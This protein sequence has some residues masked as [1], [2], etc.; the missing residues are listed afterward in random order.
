MWV[1][2]YGSTVVSVELGFCIVLKS[3]AILK[4]V[5]LD[6]AGSSIKLVRKPPS[7]VASTCSRT[8]TLPCGPCAGTLLPRCCKQ[9][10]VAM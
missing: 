8:K 10:K 2:R 6:Y 1:C 5:I 7:L 3:F 9:R 4:L